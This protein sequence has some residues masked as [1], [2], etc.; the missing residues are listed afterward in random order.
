MLQRSTLI[1]GG[2]PAIK[3]KFEKVERSI[4]EGDFA[5]QGINKAEKNN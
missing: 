5:W 3:E 4:H 2:R 1:F